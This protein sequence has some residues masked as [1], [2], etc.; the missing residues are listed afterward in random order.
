MAHDVQM[1][2]YLPRD[3]RNHVRS[4][5]FVQLE[6]TGQSKG[7]DT[8]RFC[9]SHPSGCVKNRLNGGRRQGVHRASGWGLLG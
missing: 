1:V 6:A 5:L 7:A 2:K 4:L 8:K 3:L 9:F